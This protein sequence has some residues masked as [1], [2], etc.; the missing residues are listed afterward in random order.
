MTE[1]TK[2]KPVPFFSLKF[3]D[4]LNIPENYNFDI[5]FVNNVTKESIS[6]PGI[7]TE[8]VTISRKEF[9]PDTDYMVQVSFVF[10]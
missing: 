6:V 3:D 2:I 8:S 7:K 9:K 10:I 4:R 1:E 5:R